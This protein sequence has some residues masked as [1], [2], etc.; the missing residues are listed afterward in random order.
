[1]SFKTVNNS[2]DAD[3]IYQQYL[4]YYSAANADI[5]AIDNLPYAIWKTVQAERA[6]IV[7]DQALLG[8][9]YQKDYADNNATLDTFIQDCAPLQAKIAAA[10]AQA[11]GNGSN[12]AQKIQ[13]DLTNAQSILSGI[14]TK[15]SQDFGSLN[16][17][18]SLTAILSSLQRQ[19][20]QLPDGPAKV[21]AQQ[22]FNAAIMDFKTL[23]SAIKSAEPEFN[24]LAN[25]FNLLNTQVLARLEA[26][27]ALQ[28]PT[29][30]NLKEADI[31]LSLIQKTA[32][33]QTTFDKSAMAAVTN[34]LAA[35]RAD[36]QKVHADIAPAPIPGKAVNDGWYID[37]TTWQFPI[38]EGLN[39]VNIFVGELAIVNGQPTINGLDGMEAN[40][41]S[42]VTACHAKNISVKVSIGGGGGSYDNCWDLLTQDN[43][44][45]FAKGLADFCQTNGVDG[46]DFDYEEYK[47]SDQEALV[48]TLIKQF[49]AEGKNRGLNLQT[50]LCTNAGFGT[51]YPWQAVVQNI[52][53]AAGGSVDR[54][55][56]MS[57]Y[58]PMDQEQGW[59]TGWAQWLKNR[60]GMD[61]SQVTVGL[62]DFDANAYDI[63]AFAK[64]A[65]T[66]G[67]STGYWAWNPATPDKSNQS[68]L[69]IYNAYHS[70]EDT[71]DTIYDWM[72]APLK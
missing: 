9:I 62:D 17:L 30:Q 8:P 24:I 50:S 27:A 70:E 15:I 69:T 11:M 45:A 33:E 23:E 52:L 60:Y 53:D 61:A 63:G 6:E 13:S 25:K 71:L 29:V 59:I 58:Q 44:D 28:N 4:T 56:I 1:M 41:V 43:I 26:L 46:I 18:Q 67:F 34:Q 20:N 7:Q 37:W 2:P 48:G 16:C 14:S 19:I 3:K 47:S 12:I 68:A 21:K 32:G 65:A 49:K 57:Y 31:I 54:L 66:Q 42:F 10:F 38:P 55:Y 51:S 40:L 5:Q 64:W 36:I 22:D 72:F 39:T 35:V